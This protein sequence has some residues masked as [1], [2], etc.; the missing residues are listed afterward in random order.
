MKATKD[1]V[2]SIDYTLTNEAGEVLDTSN[3]GEPLDYLHGHGQIV[4]GLERE[5]EGKRAGDSFQIKVSP[6]DGY[7]DHDHRKVMT[8]PR[9]QLPKGLAP[10]VGMQLTAQG[11]NGEQ[12]ALWIVEVSDREIKVDANHPLAGQTLHF[13]VAVR[14][15]REA[16]EEELEHGHVHGEGGH[17]H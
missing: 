8:V 17:H 12:I 2:V 16:S 9:K 3:G 7:G 5:L 10:E 4:P 1:S 11:P 13:D 15:V 6:A 14:S